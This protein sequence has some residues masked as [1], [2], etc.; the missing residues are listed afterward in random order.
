MP[1]CFNCIWKSYICADKE[2]KNK[3]KSKIV[4]FL[5]KVE[6]ID[7]LNRGMSI[8][9]VRCHYSVNLLVIHLITNYGN[10]IGKNIKGS[11]P[12]YM[13]IS[14]VNNHDP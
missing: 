4:S 8:A 7:K 1:S 3:N 10:K 11:A 14:C 6:M 13:K 2:S 9:A 12:F 5:E